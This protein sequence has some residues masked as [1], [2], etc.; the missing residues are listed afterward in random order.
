MKLCF[1]EEFEVGIYLIYYEN[2]VD[3]GRK[4]NKNF[5]LQYFNL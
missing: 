5:Y 2:C 4:L 1:V 3:L